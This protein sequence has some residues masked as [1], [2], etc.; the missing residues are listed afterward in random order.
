MSLTKYLGKYGPELGEWAKKTGKDLLK[1]KG[2]ELLDK[3][4]GKLLAAAAIPAAGVAA[5]ELG[6]KYDDFMQDR[7]IESIKRNA[8]RSA[9]DTL[10]FAEKHPLVVSGALTGASALG[11]MGNR[12]GA[13]NNLQS[14]FINAIEN[15]ANKPQR[16][17]R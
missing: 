1:T 8:K 6:P 2:G 13:D 9:L 14:L 7:A 17:R 3:H 12:G 5:H 4:G 11:S 15:Q 10:D 16:K